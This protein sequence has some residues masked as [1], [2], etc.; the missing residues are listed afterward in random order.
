[1]TPATL[2]QRII[3]LGLSEDAPDTGLQ[4]KAL[5]WL[6]NAYF[7]I[8]NEAAT[9]AGAVLAQTSTVSIT[10]G[11]GTLPSAPRRILLVKD[12][13]T[14]RVLKLSDVVSISETAKDI[15][16]PG[17]PAKYYFVGETG[18]KTFPVNTT[19]LEVT[20]IARPA[21]LVIGDPETAIKIPPHHHEQLIWA[22]LI[23]GMLYERGFGNDSLLQVANTR[24]Q[25]LKDAYM[26]ELRENTMA[27]QR[28]KL[29]DF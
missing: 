20:W 12:V 1:M 16:Q 19:S 23:E 27:P 24:K 25:S 28:V 10:S 9:Y 5:G 3:N 2:V 26:R 21:E 14:S 15:T 7:E 17:N 18:I 13:P 22:S 8:Y 4:A 11:S 6:N 29:Q